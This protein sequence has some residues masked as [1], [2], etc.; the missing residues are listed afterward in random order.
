MKKDL[1]YIARLEKAIEE[2]YGKE[3]IINPK[4]NWTDEKEKQYLSEPQ[5]YPAYKPI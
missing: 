3:A 2:K 1:D 4:S 5:C